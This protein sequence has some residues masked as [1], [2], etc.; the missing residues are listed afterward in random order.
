MIVSPQPW[1]KF[2]SHDVIWA[3]NI[4]TI[5][6][7]KWKKKPDMEY[8]CEMRLFYQRVSSLWLYPQQTDGTG[9]MHYGCMLC[10]FSSLFTSL[11]W[12]LYRPSPSLMSAVII[13]CTGPHNP[14]NYN[15]YKM[16]KPN[17]SPVLL[18]GF[19]MQS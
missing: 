11:S 10:Q 12:D 17:T 16:R 14:A 9:G 3:A 4:L 8:S 15:G 18:W 13:L 5:W 7:N 2:Y 6:K 1:L 19:L